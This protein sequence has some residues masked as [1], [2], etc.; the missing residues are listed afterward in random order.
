MANAL[1]VGAHLLDRL[2][3]LSEPAAVAASQRAIA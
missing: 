1:R 3:A 2:G